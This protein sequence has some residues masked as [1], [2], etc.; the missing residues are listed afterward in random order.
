VCLENGEKSE[1]REGEN[2]IKTI[3]SARMAK[4]QEKEKRSKKKS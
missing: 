1:L 2:P 4:S 3:F